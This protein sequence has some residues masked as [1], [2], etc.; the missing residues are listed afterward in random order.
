[1]KNSIFAN[2]QIFWQILKV[3][4]KSFLMRAEIPNTKLTFRHLEQVV[5]F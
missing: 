5:Q 2:L 3:E 1:M 4:Q